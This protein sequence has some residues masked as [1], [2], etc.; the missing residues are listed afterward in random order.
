MSW[1]ETNDL[2]LVI[3]VTTAKPEPTFVT[4]PIR[5]A[6]LS[7]APITGCL[8]LIPSL[9]PW[10]IVIVLFQTLGELLMTVALTGFVP[11][12]PEFVSTVRIP[13]AA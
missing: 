9:E 11:C 6:V 3:S 7:S 13:S 4:L 2:S 5:P 10:S 8:T 1:A 12:R